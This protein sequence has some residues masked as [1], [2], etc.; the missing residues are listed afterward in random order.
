MLLFGIHKLLVVCNETK[1]VRIAALRSFKDPTRPWQSFV[2]LTKQYHAC[3]ITYTSMLLEVET[4][5]MLIA[6][7]RITNSHTI[8]FTI[9]RTTATNNTRTH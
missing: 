2:V 4:G 7:Q 5:G 3:Q 9:E 6:T 8:Y 1:L